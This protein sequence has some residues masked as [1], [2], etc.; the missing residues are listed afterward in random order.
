MKES[1]HSVGQRAPVCGVL[2]AV[3]PLAGYGV[4]YGVAFV[5]GNSPTVA[6]GYVY[7]GVL[8]FLLSVVW[9]LVL[10]CV[11]IGRHERY[12]A[13]SWMGLA[14][15]LILFCLTASALNWF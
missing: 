9:G 12:G 14:L 8:F 1:S 3:V 15:N 2:S 10:S 6:L 13:L 11:G 4:A 5:I 7:F